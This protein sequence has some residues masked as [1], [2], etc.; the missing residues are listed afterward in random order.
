MASVLAGFNG[1]FDID[2]GQDNVGWDGI[3]G[4]QL[5]R[6]PSERWAVKIGIHHTS[7]HVG[8]ELQERTGRRR[9]DYTREEARV[10]ASWKPFRRWRLYAE[11][12]YGYK[13]ST[14]EDLQEPLRGQLGTELYLPVPES[15]VWNTYLALDFNSFEER[16]WEIDVSTQLGIRQIEGPWRFALTWM[17][18]RTPIGEFFFRDETYLGI[19]V[20]YDLG[21]FRGLSLAGP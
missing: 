4:L 11:G 5:A 10:G 13:E 7:S 19:G 12:A 21:A 2:H 20:W 14:E 16:D 3:Y 9:I 18:G 6:R 1:Q 8:D 17:S 15:D